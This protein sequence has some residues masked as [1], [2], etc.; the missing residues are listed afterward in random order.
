MCAVGFK[1]EL[2]AVRNIIL[3]FFIPFLLMLMGVAILGITPFGFHS[4]AISDGQFYLNGLQSL[5]RVLRGE[6][7]ILYGFEGGLGT[8]RWAS[9][10]WGGLSPLRLL[11]FYANYDNLP[12]MFTWI[13]I[14]NMALCGL[15]MYIL[16]AG[17]RG[18]KITHLVL[19]TSYALMGFNVI[20]CFQTI[21]FIGPQMLPLV[22]LGLYRLFK[23]RSPLLYVISFAVCTFFNFYFGFI[24]GVATLVVLI[25]Y[26]CDAEMRHKGRWKRFVVMYVIA[27]A[28]GTLLPAFMWL[29][30]LKAYSGGG[31]LDQT[32]VS[33]Y[34]FT[35]N[36]PFM[37][38]ISKLTTGANS[39]NEMVDGLPNIFCGV[40]VVAAVILYFMNAEMPIRRRIIAASVLLFYLVTFYIVPLTLL[41]HGGT[42]T[43]WFPYRYS[44]VFSFF[45]VCI[46]AE[47]LPYMIG[48]TKGEMKRCAFVLLVLFLA[49]FGVTK[50]EFVSG[51]WALADLAL[52]AAIAMLL[53]LYRRYPERVTKTLFVILLTLLVSSNLLAN[54]VES[55]R[56]VRDEEGWELD[57]EAYTANTVRSGALIDGLNSA[58]DGFFRMEKD[59]SE[60]ETIG[61]DP[62]LYGYNGVSGSGPTMR[63]FNHTQLNKLGINWYDM[64]QWYSAGVPAATDS[65]LGLNYVV[66]D[67]DLA[68]EKG[69]EK[70]IDLD[71]SYIY[72]NHHALNPAIV[73]D[74]AC[75]SIGLGDNAFRNLNTVWKKMVGKTDNVFTV[76]ND[77][78]FTIHSKI[79]G[80]TVTANELRESTRAA[81]SESEVDDTSADMNQ[82][83]NTDAYIEY[84]FTAKKDGSVYVYDTTIP[85]STNGRPS[86]VIACCGTYK[87]GDVVDGYFGFDSQLIDM[88]IEE[89][90]SKLVFAYA[91]DDVLTDYAKELLGRET[92]F[93][94]DGA[95]VSGAFTADDGQRLLVTLPRDEGWTCYIDGQMVPIDKTWDLF[96]SVE[97]PEGTHTYEMRFFP[98]W[99][100]YGFILSGI[101]LAGLVVLLLMWS[102]SKKD[103]L[104]SVS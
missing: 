87:Q 31:R 37:Q 70:V 30:A 17:I 89:Y 42:H 60:S 9:L 28:I 16:L 81:C 88:S 56:K 79:E 64:R 34:L 84:S 57:L 51:A 45:M 21:F 8:N 47:E 5:G 25:A 39:T 98:A 50:Y 65:L 36:M 19:S 97:V 104:R 91:N 69:Y 71:G 73:V 58:I 7:S 93:E 90:C 11:G 82:I 24:I 46:A 41:M 67:H 85:E 23:G 4:L 6:T 13:S 72:Q 80:Q 62:A 101:A 38:I 99:M 52:L 54:Y 61:A 95:V 12:V 102:H 92:S 27:T 33:E 18:H 44:F 55:I 103:S 3:S 29:P 77:V 63:M 53:V 49:V 32:Q 76:E 10:A 15:T 26:L 48:L 22:M 59:F 100:N 86:Q 96:M 1:R 83:P 74:E 43:N 94:A 68:L 35:E 40:L 2:K 78:S 66:T 75:Q 14:I 20:N